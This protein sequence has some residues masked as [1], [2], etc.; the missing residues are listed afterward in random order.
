MKKI[1]EMMNNC[2]FLTSEE[3][4]DYLEEAKYLPEEGQEKFIKI[5]EEAKEKQDEI[6]GRRIDENHNYAKELKKFVTKTATKLRK[7][8]EEEEQEEAINILKKL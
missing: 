8:Y 6:L 3:I 4:T 1:K 2:F 7:K 5:L